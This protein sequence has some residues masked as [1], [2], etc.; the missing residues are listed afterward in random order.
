MPFSHFALVNYIPTS[1]YNI[2]L[3]GVEFIVCMVFLSPK[4]RLRFAILILLCI[5]F[6]S[7]NLEYI[8]I[9][10]LGCIYLPIMMISKNETINHFGSPQLQ[11]V[12][13]QS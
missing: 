11:E 2:L 1:R 7:V 4:M 9:V 3:Y 12:P 10:Y 6:T 5:C 8:C 13:K